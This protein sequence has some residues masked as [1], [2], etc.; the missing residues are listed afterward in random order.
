MEKYGVVDI[1]S[2]T[3][4]LEIYNV[5]E[6]SMELFFKKKEFLGLAGYVSDGIMDRDGIEKTIEVLKDYMNI[7]D[8]IGT[9]DLYIFAT[10]AI[11]NSKNAL[12]IIHEV[13]EKIGHKIDLIS[14]EREAELGFRAITDQ[15]GIKSGMNIDIGGGSTEI[16]VYEKGAFQVSKSLTDGALSLYSRY[17]S[18]VF[19][20]KKELAKMEERINK[21]IVD[22]RLSNIVH[23]KI[24]GV[25]GTIRMLNRL[26]RSYYGEDNENIIKTKKLKKIF[27]LMLAQDKTIIKLI[28][29]IA[30]ERVHLIIPGTLILLKVCAHYSVK[31]ILV[32]DSG[33][34]VGYL[35]LKI[36]G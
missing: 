26:I 8:N 34:R 15:F 3:V 22:E 11:R 1:G 30:P 31:E 23:E 20:T 14:G 5:D 4:R 27:D 2:N 10:A 35:S 9:K 25:G 18:L 32:S 36:E 21:Y 16:T 13:E 12:E 7:C 6:N 19:P 24:F 29:K 17:I 33:V 28:L